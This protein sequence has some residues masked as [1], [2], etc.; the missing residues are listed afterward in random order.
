[1]VCLVDAVVV[2]GGVAVVD[3]VIVVAVRDIVMIVVMVAGVVVG[4]EIMRVMFVG[5]SCCWVTLLLW[6]L[7]RNCG[8]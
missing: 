4:S 7:L 3:V 8:C 1:M 5:C 2:D 6:L